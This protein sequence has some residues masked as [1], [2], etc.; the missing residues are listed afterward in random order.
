M[1]NHDFTPKNLIFSNFRG[2]GRLGGADK[3]DVREGEKGEG[4][5]RGRAG[6]GGRRVKTG[7]RRMGD[8][9]GGKRGKESENGRKEKRGRKGD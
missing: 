3:E 8:R 5:E 9:K 1:K 7:E 6:I 4:W 2:G